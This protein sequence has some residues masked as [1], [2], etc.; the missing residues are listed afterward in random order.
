MLLLEEQE[1]KAAAGFQ[2]CSKCALPFPATDKHQ[3]CLRC[4]GP[5]HR[6]RDCDLCRAMGSRALK[7][8][9]QRLRD[10]FGKRSASPSPSGSSRHPRV[11]KSDRSDP[12][13]GESVLSSPVQDMT[14]PVEAPVLRKLQGRLSRSSGTHAQSPRLQYGVPHLPGPRSRRGRV[15]SGV[16]PKWVSRINLSSDEDYTSDGRGEVEGS[17]FGEVSNAFYATEADS[18]LGSPFFV[19]IIVL[20]SSSIAIILIVGTGVFRTLSSH[21]LQL[22]L[23]PHRREISQPKNS[24]SCKQVCKDILLAVSVPVLIAVALVIFKVLGILELSLKVLIKFKIECFLL[25]Y[26]TL[27]RF[28]DILIVRLLH[29][30]PLHLEFF[31]RRLAGIIILIQL[32]ILAV[33]NINKCEKSKEPF[34]MVM[35]ILTTCCLIFWF[36]IQYKTMERKMTNELSQKVTKRGPR[37]SEARTATE[38]K[39]QRHLL[40]QERSP[41]HSTQT[42]V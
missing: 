9:E 21:K 39:E 27:N 3:S 7:N 1:K 18:E 26:M 5:E 32:I 17:Y 2:H 40:K 29:K 12:H 24:A 42:S 6:P 14:H 23:E 41:Q 22:G 11:A 28:T 36:G 4:L 30:L 34:F 25:L 31:C 13:L 19:D 37:A 35:L 38:L 15:L 33:S 8:Q 20:V 16:T 10:L